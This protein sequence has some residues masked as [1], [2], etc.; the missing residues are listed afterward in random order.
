LRTVVLGGALIFI[1][2]FGFLSLFVLFSSGPDVLVVL[3]LAVLG[4]LALGVIGGLAT[5]PDDR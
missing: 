5:P 1:A 4:L 2:V 3:S